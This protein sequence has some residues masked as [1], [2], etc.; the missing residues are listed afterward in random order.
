MK[1]VEPLTKRICH[2]TAALT[3]LPTLVLAHIY[4]CYFW[5]C[6]Q[7][8]QSNH[9]SCP[10]ISTHKDSHKFSYDTR[11]LDATL[12]SVNIFLHWTGLDFLW[13]RWKFW[14]LQNPSNMLTPP[15]LIG[16]QLWEPRYHCDIRGVSGGPMIPRDASL[17]DGRTLDR[18]RTSTQATWRR[19]EQFL[20]VQKM[21]LYSLKYI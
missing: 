3:S 13:P 1:K 9:K 14:V 21:F 19:F 12:P 15:G 5:D 18:Y 2:K 10:L 8:T 4:G 20:L 11:I 17:S 7:L 6:Y 16:A